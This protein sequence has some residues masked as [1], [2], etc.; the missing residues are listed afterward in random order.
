MPSL[1]RVREAVSLSELMLQWGRS[2]AGVVVLEVLSSVSSSSNLSLAARLALAEPV[3][4]VRDSVWRSIP[5]FR[6]ELS[7]IDTAPFQRLRRVQQL[8]FT[9]WVFPGA[10]H[11]RFEH[12][13][14]VHHLARRVLL[15]LLRLAESPPISDEDGSALL[16]AALLHDLGHYPFSH[17]VEELDLGVLRPHEVI[18]REL[19]L[20]PPIADVLRR[21][22]RVEPERVAR[23]L[24]P[25]PLGGLD[26]LLQDV[27]SGALDVDK[28]DYL[29]RDARHCNVPYGEVD[30]DRIVEALRVSSDADGNPRLALSEKGVGPFQ[31]LVFGRYMMFF[32]V[33]WHH[34]CRICTVM[35]LRAVQDALI[36]GTIQPP[37]L[38]RLDDATLLSLLTGRARPGSGAAVLARGLADRQLFKRALEYVDGDEAYALLAPLQGEPARRRALEIAWCELLSTPGRRLQGH[39]VLI[40]VPVQITFRIDTPVMHWRGRKWVALSWDRRAGLDEEGLLMLQRR[41]RR[42]RVISDPSLREIVAEREHDLL[43]L[44]RGFSVS[45]LPLWAV[46]GSSRAREE[47]ESG[48]S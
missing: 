14:G 34:T 45:E 18:S 1:G 7:L 33:Y 13:L 27:L 5:L 20:E 29:V 43:D 2:S 10:R 48:K 12:S 30:V 24:C 23:L 37:E 15:R 9:S 41:L 40:D 22:W 42:I 39:E 16:A 28:L 47:D 4:V 19:I 44:A 32:N 35:F 38:E 8:G 6:A 31:S 26:G 25:E 11:T 3:T 36:D 17:A 46:P 21:E